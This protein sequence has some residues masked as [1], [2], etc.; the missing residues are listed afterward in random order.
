[1]TIGTVGGALLSPLLGAL[2][3]RI[4]P[5]ALITACGVV[6]SLCFAAL[7]TVTQAWQYNLLLGLAFAVMTTG[8]GQVMGSVAVSRWFVRRRGR[9][10]GIVMMGASSGG[11]LFVSL[12]TVLIATIGWRMT[13][14]VQAALTAL[15]IAVPVFLL[16]IDSPESVGASDRGGLGKEGTAAPPEEH[17]WTVR[18]ALRTRAFWLTLPAVMLA[19]FAV[20]GYFA[21]AV[22]ILES[23]G[24]SRAVASTAW[25]TFFLTGIGAKFVWGFAIERLGVRY[26]LMVCL[27]AETAG[28]RLLAGANTPA[29]AFSWAVAT[30]LGHGPFLQ[31]LAMVWVD[32]FGHKSLGAIIGAVQPFIVVAGS[33]GPWMAGALFDSSGGYALFLNIGTALALTSAVIFALD[34]PPRPPGP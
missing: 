13:Y 25:A 29:E 12:T 16:M 27:L 7:A 10:M 30:G 5:R 14:L 24:L 34:R 31:L 18:A 3:D 4:G 20:L 11:L 8:I 28:I 6:A 2:I 19:S 22:P 23:H 9:A 32:Y 26:S 17:S 33:L 21:H 1:L 15:L